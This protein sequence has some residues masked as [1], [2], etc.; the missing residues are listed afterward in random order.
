MSV[1][2][3]NLPKKQIWI[4]VG[5]VVLII[6]L[7][8]SA[9]VIP[10]GHIG[11]LTFFGKVEPALLGEGVHL[12]NP[13]KKV[14]E[15]VVRTQQITEDASVPSKEGLMVD[16]DMTVLFKL[17]SKMAPQVYR[18][19]GPNYIGVIVAPQIRSVLRGVTAGYEAKALYTTEREALA[20]QLF[21]Q[22]KPMLEIRGV[23]LEKV[24]LRSVK[25]PDIVANAIQEKLKA[26]QE[27]QRMKFILDKELQEAERK[28]IE[29][30]GISDYNQSVTVGL[31]ESVLRL[32][33]IEATRELAKSE[34]S[35]VVIIGG[36]DGIPVILGQ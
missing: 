16:V 1:P 34:N 14:R 6:G 26:E 11:V 35:K 13:L 8:K 17:D 25:L 9:I 18:D 29:A 33:G 30:K 27:A 10:T 4:I 2:G 20:S 21:E 23:V 15:M 5:I 7:S 31:T 24:L 19:V 12:I 36:K 28:R 22:L 3:F 32:R